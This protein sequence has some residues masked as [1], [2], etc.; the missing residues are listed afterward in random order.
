MN[1]G[2]ILEVISD[3]SGFEKDFPAWCNTAGEE[4][5]GLKK[6]KIFT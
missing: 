4:F 1:K 3:D 2:E 6:R 5:L